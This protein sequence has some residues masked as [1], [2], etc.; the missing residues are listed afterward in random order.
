MVKTT[1][2]LQIRSY[3]YWSDEGAL[4]FDEIFKKPCFNEWVTTIMKTSKTETSL[5][6]SNS[7]CCPEEEAKWQDEVGNKQYSTSCPRPADLRYRPFH[8]SDSDLD[9]LREISLEG[10]VQ[11]EEAA[12]NLWNSTNAR[13]SRPLKQQL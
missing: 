1:F 2:D 11:A 3:F 8:L 7:R 13:S 6:I 9:E 4:I 10:D 12:Q 5:E